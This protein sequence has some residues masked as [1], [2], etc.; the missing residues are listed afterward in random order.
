MTGHDTKK[1]MCLNN[2]VQNLIE[3]GMITLSSHNQPAMD[4]NP[5]KDHETPLPLTDISFI[6]RPNKELNRDTYFHPFTPIATDLTSLNL[7]ILSFIEVVD[8]MECDNSG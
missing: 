2:K 5:L 1:C 7:L 4:E 6:N 8:D 3:K